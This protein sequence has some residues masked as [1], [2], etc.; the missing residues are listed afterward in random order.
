MYSLILAMQESEYFAAVAVHAGAW[1]TD[2]ALNAPGLA[3]RKIPIKIIIGDKDEYFSLS[4]VYKTEDALRARGIP[5]EVHVITGQRH[6]L[7]S[8]TAPAIFEEAWAFLSS[9]A[10]E[11]NPVFRIYR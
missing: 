9:R 5:V 3:I 1:T 6:A 2:G 8:R 7:T 11:Q 10:L 4:S